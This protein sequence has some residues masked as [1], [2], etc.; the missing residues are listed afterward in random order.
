MKNSILSLEY[1]YSKGNAYLS[2]SPYYKQVSDLIVTMAESY[3]DGSLVKYTNL[4]RYKEWGI[5]FT[6][7]NSLFKWWMVNLY[8][9]G[10][11]QNIPYNEYYRVICK[12]PWIKVDMVALFLPQD[13]AQL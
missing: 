11:Y 6:Y 4:K 2:I 1:S 10:S 9:K 5:D 8:A 7:S 12:S 13:V 3:E